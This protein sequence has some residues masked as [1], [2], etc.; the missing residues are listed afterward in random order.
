MIYEFCKTL[1][2]K[3]VFVRADM[4]EKIDLFLLC[5]RI[6]Q[7]QYEELVDLIGE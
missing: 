3:R 6:T 4:L 2:E 5:R 7:E 1:I